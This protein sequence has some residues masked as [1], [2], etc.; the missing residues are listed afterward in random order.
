[1]RLL[2]ALALVVL[3]A[4]VLGAQEAVPEAGWFHV[5]WRD[6]RTPTAMRSEYHV[7]IDDA[8]TWWDLDLDPRLVRV[9][10]GPLALDRTRVRIA[11]ERSS[12]DALGAG[13]PRLRIRSIGVERNAGDPGGTFGADA[14]AAV[15][16]SRPYITILCAF[17]DSPTVL[18]ASKTRMEAVMGST[19]PGMDHYYRE[20][21]EGLANLSGS[22][23]VGWYT[24][25]QP[26]SYYVLSGGAALSTL[27]RDCTAAADADVHFPSFAGINLQFNQRLDCCSWGGSRTLTLDGVTRSYP[28]TWMADWAIGHSVYAHE[29]GHSFGWAHSHGAYGAQY[30][31]KW[32]VMSN[33][34]NYRDPIFGWVAVHTIAF[35]KDRAGW[36]PAARKFVAPAA[37][38]SSILLERGAQPGGNANYLV[39]QIAIPGTASV[40]TVEAR[41]FTG[42]Y[43]LRLPAEAV[44]IHR[45]NG[46][47]AEVVDV[48]LNANPNDAAAQWLPGETFV[49][50]DAKISV[51]IEGQVGNA[52]QVRITTGLD[53][54]ALSLSRTGA[55]DS[56]MA[57]GTTPLVD[58]VAIVLT[59]N[60]AGAA[61]WSATTRQPW[62]TLLTSSGTGGGVLR[63]RR[64]ATG[65]D[66]GLYVDTITVTAL[67]A[68][69]SPARVVD[70]LRVLG[71]PTP[72]VLTMDAASRRD[73]AMA[74]STSLIRDSVML[75]F[76]G[77]G[78][79]S[80]SWTAVSHAS[81]LALVN[82]SGA[83]GGLLRWTRDPSGLTAGTYVDTITVAASGASGS[84][85]RVVDTLRVLPLPSVDAA[86]AELLGATRLTSFEK[87]HLD[88][89]GNRDAVYNLGDF[90]AF[91]DRSGLNLSQELR[92]RLLGVRRE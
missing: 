47:E 28:M 87:L 45:V 65:L 5:I 62:T 43:D 8:G 11:A 57:G 55:S 33:A 54:L 67:G 74:R 53:L 51:V 26:R 24:L 59:G 81:W 42:N 17:A 14:G 39:A 72:L 66:A 9:P 73:S 15:S 35:H 88:H 25:P 52:F 36:I 4:S 38:S 20:M 64:D 1:M 56:A 50:S 91:L 22:V 10:G 23:V 58:S 70:T 69:G 71:S 29:I 30:D 3:Q 92:A 2:G 84:P 12:R 40:Y 19:Y 32:D 49:D 75:S 18:P 37:G 90:L 44:V 31:S 79:T 61:G 83:G 63:W 77:T 41:R 86:A 16:G 13:T 60:G 7:L 80:V 46:F 82:P 27:S 85:A 76:T 6:A 78:A 68:T 34:N 48:D 89:E 21:S